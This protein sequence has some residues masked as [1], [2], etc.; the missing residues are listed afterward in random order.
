MDPVT[1][2]N[3]LNLVQ[4]VALAWIARCTQP[5]KDSRGSRR[6]QS[7]GSDSHK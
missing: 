7:D 2:N 1:F 6:M 3:I 4:V 5:P